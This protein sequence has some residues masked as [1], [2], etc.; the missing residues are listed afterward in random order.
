M[1]IE[2]VV[3]EDESEKGTADSLRII[4]PKTK[5]N[6][7]V[8]S[9]DLITKVSLSELANV[10]RASNA[11]ITALV[12]PWYT[13]AN[14]EGKK[15]R[16]KKDDRDFVGLDPSDNRI[17]FLS[18]E[19]DLDD[20]IVFRKGQL[21]VF[22]HMRLYTTLR[23]C[24]L[25]IISQTAVQALMNKPEIAMLRCEF[26]PLLVR[27]QIKQVANAEQFTDIYSTLQQ[28]TEGDIKFA[29]LQPPEETGCFVHITEDF[30]VRV[31]QQHNYIKYNKAVGEL[32][33]DMLPKHTPPATVKSFEETQYGVHQ[34]TQVCKVSRVSEEVAIEG[35]C[36]VKRS[37]I[38]CGVKI[39]AH[40][41][42]ADCVIMSGVTIESNVTL[43]NSVICPAAI[44]RSKSNLKDC[45]VCDGYEVRS[46]SEYT[47]E[48]LIGDEENMMSFSIDNS[49]NNSS[50]SDEN[51][52]R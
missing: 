34:Q 40:S 36:S 33:T 24:H 10:H 32:M 37:F 26:L 38:G 51:V 27:K 17:L 1:A 47:D 12:A 3:I 15:K 41:R 52:L 16:N 7:L 14:P 39:G 4:A 19:K 31:N 30:T 25:Y 2:Y 5:S 23:D 22:P 44:I 49:A 13:P 9:G 48:T 28:E 11:S 45:R 20:E 21:S 46:G 50:S 43:S 42:I 35:K 29:A 18:N 6:L 8:I